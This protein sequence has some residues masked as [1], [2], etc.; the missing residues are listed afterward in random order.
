MLPINNAHQKLDELAR[1]LNEAE[2]QR[3]RDW[4]GDPGEAG[5]GAVG[6]GE[7]GRGRAC[8]GGE[9]A[10]RGGEEA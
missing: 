8:R 4:Q 9:A 10:G 1:A 5:G 3:P 7:E 6:G 2:C